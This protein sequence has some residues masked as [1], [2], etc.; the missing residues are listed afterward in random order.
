MLN[1][2]YFCSKNKL[3]E[4]NQRNS[5]LKMAGKGHITKL[6]VLEFPFINFEDP[7]KVS[8]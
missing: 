5:N 2:K 8:K 6:P 7:N 4:Q 1:S 3:I